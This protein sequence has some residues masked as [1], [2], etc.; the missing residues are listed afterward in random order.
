MENGIFKKTRQFF[1]YQKRIIWYNSYEKNEQKFVTFLDDR[2]RTDEECN[3]LQTDKE[4]LKELSE[5]EF[6]HKL[7]TFGT[8]T[9]TYDTKIPKTPEEL[10]NNLGMFFL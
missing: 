6:S 3:F 5:E 8:L 9:L 2:L 4:K 10:R 7:S 1:V